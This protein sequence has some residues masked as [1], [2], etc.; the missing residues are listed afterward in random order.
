MAS[1]QNTQGAPLNTRLKNIIPRRSI[2]ETSPEASSSLSGYKERQKSAKQTLADASAE[3]NMAR[4]RNFDASTQQT[5]LKGVMDARQYETEYDGTDGKRKL[6]AAM[7]D[8]AAGN[9]I[10][11]TYSSTSGVPDSSNEK[12]AADA[13]NENRLA[14]LNPE[15]SFQNSPV[16]TRFASNAAAGQSVNPTYNPDKTQIAAGSTPAHGNEPTEGTGAPA[17]KP[18]G[19]SAINPTPMTNQQ[20]AYTPPPNALTQGTAPSGTKKPEDEEEE[21]KGSSL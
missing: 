12:S 9:P 20:A 10:G 6:A 3:E 11:T 13:D 17:A 8:F 18:L 15:S 1:N 2:L 21:P 16:G 4:A 19:N 5:A 7:K 14:K